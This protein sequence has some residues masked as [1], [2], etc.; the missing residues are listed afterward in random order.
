[1][2]MY[3]GSV[4]CA[5]TPAV[6]SNA[7]FDPAVKFAEWRTFAWISDE[8]YIVASDDPRPLNPRTPIITE[9]SIV[10]TL[11]EKGF[12]EVQDVSRAD[13]VVSYTIGGRDM[14]MIEELPA[15]FGRFDWGWGMN[16]WQMQ[17]RTIDTKTVETKYVEGTLAIDIFDAQSKQPAW[18]GWASA[19]L[20]SVPAS[21]RL[22]NKAV[23]SI[24]ARFPPRT[25]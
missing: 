5:P 15:A 2:L 21:E 3:L 6:T 23:N 20:R 24:L 25:P 7:E 10:K 13:F 4:G 22:I 12:V 14:T 11:S 16:T 17:P 1:M 9:A 18:H 19:A 8:P